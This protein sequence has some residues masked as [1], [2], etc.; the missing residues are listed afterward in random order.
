LW[1]SMRLAATSFNPSFNF[2]SWCFFAS[3]VLTSLS[4]YL[5][6]RITH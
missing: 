5:E 3:N 4:R 1:S 6:F 2:N